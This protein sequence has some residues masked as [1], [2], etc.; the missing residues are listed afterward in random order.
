MLIRN[1]ND[2][3]ICYFMRIVYCICFVIVFFSCE[4]K[5]AVE[6][7]KYPVHIISEYFKSNREL[8]KRKDNGDTSIVLSPIMPKYFNGTENFI[9]DDSSNIYYYQLERYFSA[10]GCGTDMEKDSI[11]FFLNLKPESLI[12]LPIESIDEFLRL[13]FR[14]GERN[15]VKIA[16]QRIL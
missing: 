1:N 10:A 13:N 7:K 6:E 4:K 12:K 5:L 14:K 2:F 15:A 16:S 3:V 9:L 8:Q 11:P